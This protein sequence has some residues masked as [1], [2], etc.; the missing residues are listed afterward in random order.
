IE[1][2]KRQVSDV[3]DRLRQVA[4]NLSDDPKLNL[5][6]IRIRRTTDIAAFVALILSLIAMIFQLQTYFSS[7]DVRSFPPRRIAIYNSELFKSVTDFGDPPEVLFAAITSYSNR[8][9]KD[10]PAIVM[11]EF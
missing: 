11:D 5:R 1:T 3:E 2:L 10:H 7:P 4:P 9:S 8:A 6:V